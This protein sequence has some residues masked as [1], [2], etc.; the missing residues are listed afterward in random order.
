MM[1]E[2]PQQRGRRPSFS[3]FWK[4]GKDTRKSRDITFVQERAP[5]RLQPPN[6][7]QHDDGESPDD[8][9]GS[10]DKQQLRNDKAKARRA[11]VRKA[12]IQHRQRKAEYVKQLE[13][14]VSHFRE[15]I[16]LTEI[17]ADAIRIENEE[18]RVKLRGTTGRFMTAALTPGPQGQSQLTPIDDSSKAE[19]LLD[20]S[21]S[22][23]L[24]PMKMEIDSDT[25]TPQSYYPADS[26]PLPQPGTGTTEM[27]A[28]IN[29]DDIA[30]SLRTDSSLGTPC[31]HISPM[32]GG[33]SATSPAMTEGETMLSPAQEH[34]AINFIL[35]LE[36][37]CWNHFWLGDFPDHTHH[38]PNAMG[39]TLMASTY[40]MASAPES[41]FM[42][43]KPDLIARACNGVK[44]TPPVVN[45]EWSTTGISLDSLHGLALS[46]NPGGAE[47]TPVQA[48]FEL[49]A[50]YPVERLL[51]PAVVDSLK[52]EFNGVVKCLHY[53]AVIE[54]EAFESVTNRRAS[55][56]LPPIQLAAD[57]D[58]PGLEQRQ[59]TFEARAAQ[60][61][62]FLLYQS[63]SSAAASLG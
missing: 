27:F 40:C 60:L 6:H 12:Q 52:Q 29:I 2:Q 61:S 4:K 14:D 10:P 48:W 34:M 33:S 63:G 62:M 56:G 35:A 55:E 57:A 46:L 44:P 1:T 49:S 25:H 15:L 43:R 8:S 41:V 59:W 20:P 18:I 16:S 28:D 7:H 26:S 13:L 50:R 3:A 53:G 32:S 17:E 19:Q 39:H 36:H 11:Q 58:G 38:G 31:F 5:D 47:L 37:V 45:F 54:R 9:A 21:L 42:G 51:E 24:Q 22:L 23:G 30:V